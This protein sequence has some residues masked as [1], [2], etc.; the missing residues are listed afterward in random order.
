MTALDGGDNRTAAA[1]F[2]S[3][4]STHPLDARCEDAAYIR[5]IALQRTGDAGAMKE[6]AAHYLRDYPNG[7]RRAEV[8][9]LAH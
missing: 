2:A 8:A 5:V 4:V 7:F 6:A 9:A 1:R 3:F